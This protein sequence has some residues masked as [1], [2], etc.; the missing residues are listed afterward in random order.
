MRSAPNFVSIAWSKPA[1]SSSKSVLSA[2]FSAA[3]RLESLAVGAQQLVQPL[4]AERADQVLD[5]ERR[6]EVGRR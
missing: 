4:V 1:C 3:S 6:L 2:A 5:D